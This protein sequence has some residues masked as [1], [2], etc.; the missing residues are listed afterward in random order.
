MFVILTWRLPEKLSQEDTN[1]DTNLKDNY[2]ESPLGASA[3]SP[4]T[5]RA[6][7]PTALPKFIDSKD[8]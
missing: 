1:T 6:S 8:S 5:Q 2:T 3:G 7:G 4:C